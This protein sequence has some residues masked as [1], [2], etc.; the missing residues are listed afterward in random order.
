MVM[1]PSVG[2]ELPVL[3]SLTLLFSTFAFGL[4]SLLDTKLSTLFK[5][6]LWLSCN[7]QSGTVS[8][9]IFEYVK[10]LLDWVKRYNNLKWGIEN[11]YSS[12]ESGLIYHART[13]L[14]G[15]IFKEKPNNYHKGS[16]HRYLGPKLEQHTQIT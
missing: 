8:Y 14:Y 9:H 6:G 11:I 7:A 10:T 1:C 4:E 16:N 12:N 2:Q 15:S 13:F 5:I 3:L